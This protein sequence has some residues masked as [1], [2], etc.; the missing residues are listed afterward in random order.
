[1]EKIFFFSPEESYIMTTKSKIPKKF[2]YFLEI[3]QFFIN[4][5]EFKIEYNDC[6]SPTFSH[7]EFLRK[8]WKENF[9]FII[10][11]L[12]IESIRWFLKILPIIKN[13]SWAKIIV[14]WEIVNMAPNFFE[15]L[16][17]DAIIVDWDWELSI[18]SAIKFLSWKEDSPSWFRYYNWNKWIKTEH[19]K[20]ILNW[21]WELVNPKD[22]EELVKIYASI[23]WWE[24]TLTVWRWCVYWCWFCWATATFGDKDRRKSPQEIVER[25]FYIQDNYPFIQSFKLFAPT[26]T[27]D[28]SWVTDF[29]NLIINSWRKVK[30]CATT[31]LD[32]NSSDELISLLAK[33]WCY[34]IAIWVETNN[35]SSNSAIQKYRNKKILN[36]IWDIIKKYTSNGIKFRSLFMLGIPWQTKESIIELFELFE[37]W[38]ELVSLRP[39]AYSPRELYK[40]LDKDRKLTLEVIESLDKMTYYENNIEWLSESEF[41]SLIF[42]PNNFRN[43]LLWK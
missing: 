38:W 10:V 25:I 26:L 36:N 17:I 11:N 4:L 6:I 23:T 35:V 20:I 27:N 34:K 8:I 41:L 22:F 29:C 24:I 32:C 33:S 1:M 21:K 3:I 9:D 16:G 2:T 42:N 18:L 15:K 31:R 40:I 5:Q 7:W 13:I 37:K 28:I 39:S 30:W 19:W 12:R 43:I 14:Y